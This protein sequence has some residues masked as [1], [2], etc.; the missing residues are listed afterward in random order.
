MNAFRLFASAL[1]IAALGCG[2]SPSSICSEVCDCEGCSDTEL[3]D[4]VD[5]LEDAEKKAD[6][7]GC[8]DQY[9]DLSACF[10]DQLECRDG[11]IDADG[12]DSEEDLLE[13]C[14]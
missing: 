1:T 10:A 12:C 4:C 13:D 5:N 2:S 8:G 7:E 9:S 14:L 6:D 3:D 11:D